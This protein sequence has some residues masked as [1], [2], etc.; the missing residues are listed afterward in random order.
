[1]L[2]DCCRTPSISRVDSNF[3]IKGRIVESLH[4]RMLSRRAK[5][6]LCKKQLTLLT[7]ERLFHSTNY[8]EITE[9]KRWPEL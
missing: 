5:V 4:D 6:E 9:H 3:T 2:R 7:D 1:M 8:Q